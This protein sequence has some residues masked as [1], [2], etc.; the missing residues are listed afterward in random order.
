M[1]LGKSVLKICRKFIGERPCR[2]TI[3]IK[4]LYDFIDFEIGL[5]HGC[6]PVNM[7]HILRTSFPRDTSGRPLLKLE[8]A[9]NFFVS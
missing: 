7:L 3:S 9:Y 1:F 2:G 4:L 6:S 8:T 5:R